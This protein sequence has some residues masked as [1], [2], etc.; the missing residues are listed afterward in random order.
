MLNNSAIASLELHDL[1]YAG[2]E[3]QNSLAINRCL[4]KSKKGWSECESVVYWEHAMYKW[5][6]TLMRSYENKS[7]LEVICKFSEDLCMYMISDNAR[8][9]KLTP[10]LTWMISWIQRIHQENMSQNLSWVQKS[11]S[12]NLFQFRRKT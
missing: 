3:N 12:F 8:N 11:L 10:R 9:Q 5:K 4:N 2:G 1:G 6:K 7:S